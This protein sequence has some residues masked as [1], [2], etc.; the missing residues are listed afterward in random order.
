MQVYEKSYN[1]SISL[2]VQ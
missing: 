1:I 2:T